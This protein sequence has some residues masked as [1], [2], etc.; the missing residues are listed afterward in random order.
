M[1]FG[2][3]LSMSPGPLNLSTVS[4]IWNHVDVQSYFA[5]AIPSVSI[6]LLGRE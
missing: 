5:A 2:R 3:A 6:F 1:K 4:R